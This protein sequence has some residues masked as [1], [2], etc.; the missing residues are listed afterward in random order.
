MAATKHKHASHRQHTRTPPPSPPCTPIQPSTNHPAPNT[1]RHGHAVHT[2]TTHSRLVRVVFRPTAVAMCCAP[3]P[4]MELDPRL[5]VRHHARHTQTCIT[6]S[7]HAFTAPPPC[8][9]TQHFTNHPPPAQT[10]THT[11][12][13]PRSTHKYHA[14]KARQSRVPTHSRR[15]ML[16]STRADGV[17]SKTMCASPWPPPHKHASH[18]KHM[19]PPPP[20][21]TPTRHFTNHTPPPQPQ[22]HNATA[23]RYIHTSTTHLRLVKV[24]FRPTAVAMCCAPASPMELPPRLCVRYHARHHTHA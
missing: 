6:P 15:N 4:P 13:R 2:N 19:H 16:C 3:T 17:P 12:P 20:M 10:Q 1:P 22:T 11:T 18:R 23:T 24:V 7:T 8:T 21:C 14:L 5:R 9:P